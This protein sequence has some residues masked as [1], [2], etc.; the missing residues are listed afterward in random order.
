MSHDRFDVEEGQEVVRNTIVGGR[1][2]ARRKRR[3]TIP[4]GLEKVLARAAGDPAFRRRL[5]EDRHAALAHLGWELVPS[6][7]I[8]L[9]SV[10]DGVLATLI[11]RIDLKQHAR[12]RFLKGIATAAFATAAMTSGVACT[13]EGDVATK[14]IAPDDVQADV[15]SPADVLDVEETAGSRGILPEVDVP[16]VIKGIEPDEVLL[17]PGPPPD[18]GILPEEV[19]AEEV[20]PVGILDGDPE[21]IDVTDDQPA[22]GGI[23]P[24]VGEVNEVEV[25]QGQNDGG[26]RPDL[27]TTPE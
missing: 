1:P 12:R 27:D 13:H 16:D 10:P 3:I 4:I 20:F 22:V 25:D 11:D 21:V 8:I 2:R 17:D 26:V 5:F 15:L 23:M 19:E 9:G 7:A 14:G 24:D 6:E 18:A